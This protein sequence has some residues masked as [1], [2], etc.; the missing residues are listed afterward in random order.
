MSKDALGEADEFDIANYKYSIWGRLFMTFINW[1]P[2]QAEVRFGEFRYDQAHHSHEYGRFRMFAKAL[3][4]NYL[5]TV[6]KFVPIPYLTGKVTSAAFG[7]DAL[8]QRAKEVY[9][10][11]IERAKFLGKYDENTFISEGEFID[12]FI[13]GVDSTFA[14]MRTIILMMSFF[15]FALAAPDDDDDSEEKAWKAMVRK[16][17]D[18]LSDE[19]GFFYSPKSF[20]DILGNRPP[21]LSLIRDSYY[22]FTNITQEVFGFGLEQVGWDEKGIEMQEKAKPVKRIFRVFPVTKEIVNYIPAV[23]E[24]MAKEWGVRI[25]DRRGF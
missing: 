9:K 3:S 2:R 18:K 5:Q 21:V 23:D 6:S 7:K 15:F 1:I 8:I 25:N 22:M 14:E 12:M 11:K 20:I 17:M 24:D 4:A 13:K 16:Q 19:V 10:E